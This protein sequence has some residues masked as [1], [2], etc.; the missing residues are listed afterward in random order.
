M[1]HI[2]QVN[3]LNLKFAYFQIKRD[4]EKRLK[5]YYKL[6]SLLANRF[7]LMDSLERVW[8]IESNGGKNP[9]EPGAIAVSAWTYELERGQS[10]ADALNGWV[11]TGEKLMLVVGDV[12]KLDIALRNV[13]KVSEGTKRIKDPL[14]SALAYPFFLLL[15]VMGMIVAVGLYLVPMMTGATKGGQWTGMAGSLVG[16]SEFMKT[17][18]YYLPA[19]FGIVMALIVFSFQHLKGQIR[20]S[21]DK[22]PPWSLFRMF[23]GVGWLMSLSAMVRAGTP[24]T[25]AMEV[26]RDNGSPY[27]AYNLSAALTYMQMGLNLGQSLHKTG[28]GFPEQEIIGDLNIYSELDDF[29]AAVDNLANTYL[30]NSIKNIEKQAGALNTIALLAIT[31][32][33]GWVLMGTFEMQN[34]IQNM[35]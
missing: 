35:M 12:S 8:G 6:L 26:L 31:G 24:I 20:A 4:Q 34:Q 3:S 17:S 9:D 23:T 18:W 1:R 5:I 19:T 11:P 13:I 27:L 28:L 7:S 29:E 25:K 15:L 10:F 16:L 14:V 33:I 22:F 30:E 2:S 32:V 21:I